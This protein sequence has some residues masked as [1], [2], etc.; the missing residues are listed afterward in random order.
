MKESSNQD[1]FSN[2]APLSFISSTV[3]F[4]VPFLGS[5]I[6]IILGEVAKRGFNRDGNIQ[7]Y[8][9]AK[10]GLIFGYFGLVV[11]CSIAFLMIYEI[12]SVRC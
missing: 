10:M 11:W 4:F 7:G 6:G 12:F 2:L 3:G 8:G 1:Y 9:L 5:L